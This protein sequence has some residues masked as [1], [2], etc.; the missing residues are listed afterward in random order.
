M[1]QGEVSFG[2]DHRSRRTH[3]DTAERP[4]GNIPLEN[5]DGQRRRRAARRK[6]PGL[7]LASRS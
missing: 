1:W 2:F 4:D 7:H 6:A 5:G 3:P